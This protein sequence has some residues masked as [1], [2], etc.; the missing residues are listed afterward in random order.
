MLI[1]SWQRSARKTLKEIPQG[2]LGGGALLP[3]QPM[4]KYSISEQQEEAHFLPCNLKYLWDITLPPLNGANNVLFWMPH[5][6]VQW[7]RREFSSGQMCFVDMKQMNLTDTESPF[8]FSFTVN[9]VKWWQLCAHAVSNL[10]LF[11]F[12]CS[13]NRDKGFPEWMHMVLNLH[14]LGSFTSSSLQEEVLLP[15]AHSVV[16]FLYLVDSIWNS[17]WISSVS[18]LH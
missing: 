14:G 10:S 2:E 12:R 4:S 16:L 8:F 6:S 3:N 9:C 18:W 11:L 17:F 1:V 15:H 5:L 7:N 13:L